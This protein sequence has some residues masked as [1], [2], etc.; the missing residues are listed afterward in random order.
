MG[1]GI[2]R[3]SPEAYKFEANQLLLDVHRLMVLICADAEITRLSNAEGLRHL[4]ELQDRFF[5]TE[6][7]KLLVSIAGAFRSLDG[8]GRGIR[9]ASISPKIIGSMRQGTYNRGTDLNFRAACNKILHA[10]RIEIPQQQATAMDKPGH[11]EPT[12]S[13]DF[14]NQVYQAWEPREVSYEFYGTSIVCYEKENDAGD[15]LIAEIDLGKLVSAALDTF[16][17]V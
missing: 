9:P 13:L 12:L 7:S 6:V 10:E 15:T 11:D 2:M 4:Q 16:R 5:P 1:V 3:Q 17:S 14:A 8:D